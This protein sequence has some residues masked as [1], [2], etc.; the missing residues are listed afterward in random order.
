MRINTNSIKIRTTENTIII[1]DSPSYQSLK[2]RFDGFLDNLFVVAP[3][4]GFVGEQLAELGQE[5]LPVTRDFSHLKVVQD[6]LLTSVRR[7]VAQYT[8]FLN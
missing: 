3:P 7:K 2:L 5:F 8:Y 1:V 6:E 4:F